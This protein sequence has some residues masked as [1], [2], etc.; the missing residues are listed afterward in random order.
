MAARLDFIIDQGATFTTTIELTDADDVEFD[1]EL[2]TGSGQIRKNYSSN[3]YT[4]FAV[5]LDDATAE[6]TISL[7]PEQTANLAAGRYVYDVE[8]TD[9]LNNVIRVIEGIITVSPQVTR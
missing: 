6:M 5:A 9:D 3:T 8:F 4:S 1:L 7:T 2:Y